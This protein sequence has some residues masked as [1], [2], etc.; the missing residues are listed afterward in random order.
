M[1]ML[2]LVPNQVKKDEKALQAKRITDL[3]LHALTV[4]QELCVDQEVAGIEFG[5]D[6]DLRDVL[7]GLSRPELIA[8]AQS[9][10]SMV[11]A[12]PCLASAVNVVAVDW[13]GR[14][15]LRSLGARTPDE[16]RGAKR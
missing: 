1:A 7:V 2:S 6:S 5:L 15:L 11:W 10:Y 13:A 14:G 16:T 9:G 12:R 8:L 3:N 4:M